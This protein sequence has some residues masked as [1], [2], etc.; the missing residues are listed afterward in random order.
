MRS[1]SDSGVCAVADFLNQRAHSESRKRLGE[2]AGMADAA[3]VVQNDINGFPRIVGHVDEVEVAGADEFVFVLQFRLQ[4]AQQ[5]AP[6]VA[7]EQDEREIAGC[8]P[9]ARA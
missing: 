8:A 2:D 4:P 9:S 1:T 3:F 6:V 5:A 7:P